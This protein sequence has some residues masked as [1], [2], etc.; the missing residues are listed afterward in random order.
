MKI[1]IIE[2][3]PITP[4]YDAGSRALLDFYLSLQELGHETC[5]LFESEIN[6]EE[7]L[8]LIKP[9]VIFVSRPGLYQRTHPIYKALNCKVIYIAHDLHF[10]RLSLQQKLIGNLSPI[11]VRVMRN[12]EKFC[13]L[14]SDF[15]IFP[16]EE[17][18]NYANEFFKTNKAIC[19]NYFRFENVAPKQHAGEVS[20]LIFVGGAAHMPNR[21]GVTWFIENVWPDIKKSYSNLQFKVVGAWT[22]EDS[23]ELLRPGIQFT[24]VLTEDELETV[25]SESDI[26]IS[27]LRFGAGMKRKT[28][29]YMSHGLP[30]VTT[31]FGIEGVFS[32]SSQ[33]IVLADSKSEWVEAMNMVN[34]EPTRVELGFQAGDFIQKN[35]STEKQRV[36][37]DN[38]VK[39]VTSNL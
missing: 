20:R 38:L 3:A 39:L 19:V 22:L 35:F 30:V 24:G 23:R 25:I 12:I 6:L 36:D 5:F 31:S 1:A 7:S 28:L 2:A 16:T 4:E 15:S 37:L 8:L 32:G 29:N 18:A 11:A 26:G 9:N 27:P 14:N 33:G 34:D 13:V 10:R 21:D 17:E